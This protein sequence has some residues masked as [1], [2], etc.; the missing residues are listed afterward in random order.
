MSAPVFEEQASAKAASSL[1]PRWQYLAV[2]KA[3]NF[4]FEPTDEGAAAAAAAAAEAAAK[5]SDGAGYLG[6]NIA[7]G[8][9]P[10]PERSVEA[11]R[12]AIVGTTDAGPDRFARRASAAF[13]RCLC[14][15]LLLAAHSHA[16]AHRVHAPS[17]P[18]WE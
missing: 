12:T 13:C 7:S 2:Q 17:N 9:P 8:P 11:R 16:P 15:L 18:W 5:A 10:L 4:Y 3:F 6:Y 14:W 1:P